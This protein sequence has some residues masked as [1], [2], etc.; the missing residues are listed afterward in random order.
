ML[1][2]SRLINYIVENLKKIREHIINSLEPPKSIE[3]S[4]PIEVKTESIKDS[5]KNSINSIQNH[6]IEYRYYYYGIGAIVLFC[7]GYVYWEEITDSYYY[8]YDKFTS[9]IVS[10]GIYRAYIKF[11]RITDYI[12]S[13]FPY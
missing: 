4:K 5:L 12:Y 6:F 8:I 10:T 1:F 7:Y 3:P 11:R 13:W 2:R 9:L